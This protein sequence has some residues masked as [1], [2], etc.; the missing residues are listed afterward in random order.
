M[1]LVPG[2]REV[3][4][5][6]LLT[7]ARVWSD[8]S[9][10]TEV[11]GREVP[12][13]NEPVAVN[14]CCSPAATE[15]VGGFTVIDTSAA[16]AT[17]E[18][19]DEPPP[20]QPA[21]SARRKMTKRITGQ[22]QVLSNDIVSPQRQRVYEGCRSIVAEFAGGGHPNYGK[23]TCI[24]VR[25]ISRRNNRVMGLVPGSRPVSLKARSEAAFWGMFRNPCS[26]RTPKLL[27]H[28]GVGYVLPGVPERTISGT[29]VCEKAATETNTV[30]PFSHTQTL[31]QLAKSV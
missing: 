18:V 4:S 21:R 8:V 22:R 31:R 14:C 24:A 7:L 19:V 23:I 2:C 9:H 11:R 26:P 27:H 1:V 20:P 6:A 3:A 13:V 25:V 10:V 28:R 15:A 12:S 17:V 29:G 16:G 30:K 5:P